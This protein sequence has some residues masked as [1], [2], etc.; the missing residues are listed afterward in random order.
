MTENK[1]P[2]QPRSRVSS[3]PSTGSGPDLD[4]DGVVRI[5]IIDELT[6]KSRTVSFELKATALVDASTFMQLHGS[7]Q[8]R[9]TT[10]PVQVLT[11]A[12]AKVSKQFLAM[13][14]NV[15]T[16]RGTG[17]MANHLV[18]TDYRT[19]PARF[20]V[21]IHTEVFLDD[22]TADELADLRAKIGKRDVGAIVTALV[23]IGWVTDKDSL[24]ALLT[25]ALSS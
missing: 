21:T 11:N 10:M 12:R 1:P 15:V 22:P 24:T 2:A 6:Q 23:N 18:S 14:P 7:F 13:L 16:T 17:G 19:D 20:L 4:K 5:R 8:P 3:R 25:A 9:S